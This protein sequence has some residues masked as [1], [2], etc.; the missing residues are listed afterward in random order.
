V[1]SAILDALDDQQ[2]A[3]AQALEGP[4]AVRA[5]AGTGKTRAITHRIAYACVTGAHDPRQSLALTFTNRAA[6]E[7]RARLASL[8]VEGVQVRTFHA[9]ALRQLRYFWPRIVNG[10]LPRIAPKSDPLFD[11]ATQRAQLR[12]GSDLL[13]QAR[14]SIEALRMKRQSPHS[15]E[16]AVFETVDCDIDEADLLTLWRAYEQVK[17][18]AGVMDFTDVL[19]VTFGMFSEHPELLAQVHRTYT[20]FTVDEYQD[21]SPLQWDLLTAWRGRHQ[22]ICVVGDPNQ[23]I[24]GFAGATPNYLLQFTDEFATGTT[25]E[26]THCYR[27]TPQ[28]VQRA[29]QLMERS[30][31]FMPLTSTRDPGAEPTMTVYDSDGAEAAG[32][33]TAIAERLANGGDPRGIAI[34]FRTNAQATLIEL[35]LADAGIATVLRGGERFFERPEVKEAMLRMRA[36]TPQADVTASVMTVLHDM[37]WSEAA[38]EPRQRARWE[39]LS[40]IL[41]MSKDHDWPDVGTFV[42][43]LFMRARVEHVPTPFGV[44]LS[45]LH[46]AK[47]LEWSEVYMI[48]C[49]EGLLPLD[50]PGVDVDEERR[51]AYVGITRASDALHISWARSRR[52]DGPGER[53]CSRFFSG[54]DTWVTKAA[55]VRTQGLGVIRKQAPPASC[56][57]CGRGLTTAEERTVMRCAICPRDVD[58]VLL[59]TLLSWRSEA[60]RDRSL[61]EYQVLTDHAVRAI[62]ELRPRSAD[63][64]LVIPG[65]RW[66]GQGLVEVLRLIDEAGYPLIED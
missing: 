27:S 17:V 41:A 61:P 49:S 38:P 14:E 47:G 13:R 31:T 28:I 5:G 19:E 3:V 24:Y 12:L 56:R 32:I 25:L 42:D 65:T 43:H 36:A 6:G 60:A 15:W 16:P 54:S 45:T 37:G 1:S 66:L 64:V 18:D 62:A 48:G 29:N 53:V 9:A 4:V 59:A 50:S 35:A 8:G 63:E 11:Q 40:T 39:S 58:D 26:L 2:R 7:M 46:A 10:G 52:A 51:L 33:A 34:V 30:S 21:V 44:T 55:Q 22:S 20:W 23:T 57:L